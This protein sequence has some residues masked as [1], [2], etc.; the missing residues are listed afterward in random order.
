M[1]KKILQT[2]HHLDM[3]PLVDWE[4][5]L[6]PHVVT[7]RERFAETR[8][9]PKLSSICQFTRAMPMEVVSGV[10]GKNNKS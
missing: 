10:T 8:L 6:L 9:D 7:W 3:E 2:H 1:A 5:D 4:L